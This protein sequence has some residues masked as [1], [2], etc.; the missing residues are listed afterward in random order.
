L[1]ENAAVVVER[2]ARGPGLLGLAVRAQAL[3]ARFVGFASFGRSRSGAWMTWLSPISQR[4]DMGHPVLWR[5][6]NW[7]GTRLSLAHTG[8]HLHISGAAG[9]LILCGRQYSPVRVRQR[10]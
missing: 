10:I 3:A 1:R 7:G 5:E 8:V 2:G 4:R 6:R 9:I